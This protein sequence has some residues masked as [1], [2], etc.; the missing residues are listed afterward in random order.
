M[1]TGFLMMALLVI[2]VGCEE[3][4]A[5]SGG[6]KNGSQEVT[7]AEYNEVRAGMTYEA[8]SAIFDREPSLH[9]PQTA[10]WDGKN[11]HIIVTFVNGITQISNGSPYKTGNVLDT[12]TDRVVIMYGD[13]V[14]GYVNPA[15]IV[16]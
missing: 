10:K 7:R 14:I 12:S 5:D 9:I 6:G 2:G 15:F 16:R 11:T 3:D 1:L 13:S 4:N 8:V